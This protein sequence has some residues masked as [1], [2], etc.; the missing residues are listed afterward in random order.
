MYWRKEF[1]GKDFG[2]VRLSDLLSG[3]VNEYDSEV[4]R[5]RGNV[6]DDDTDDD[7]DNDDDDN[8]VVEKGNRLSGSMTCE[9]TRNVRVW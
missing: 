9:C 8:M 3:R 5:L 1:V 2:A 4:S 6:L 7:D